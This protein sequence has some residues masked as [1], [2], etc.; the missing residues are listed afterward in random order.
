MPEPENAGAGTSTDRSRTCFFPPTHPIAARKWRNICIGEKCRLDYIR[1]H[2]FSGEPSTRPMSDDC[3][4]HPH[5]APFGSSKRPGALRILVVEDNFDSAESLALMLTL[6]GF[7][8]RV[9][10][11]GPE[12]LEMA[13][14]DQPD[15]VL[16]DIGLPVLN[17][18]EVA[19]RLPELA[20]EKRPLLI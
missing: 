20:V 3:S 2:P 8:V 11:G 13:R 7:E 16:L 9:A 1:Y 5:H 18:Y 19:K 6:Y 15:V 10:H 4:F 12:A 17:G 14:A